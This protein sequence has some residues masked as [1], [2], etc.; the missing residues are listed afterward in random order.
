MPHSL[1]DTISQTCS[2][3]LTRK[4]HL[5]PTNNDTPSTGGSGA[6]VFIA[7]DE[8]SAHYYFIKH[9]SEP[10]NSPSPSISML[11]AEFVGVTELCNTQTMKVPRPIVCGTH[12]QSDSRTSFLV[13]EYVEL[14]PFPEGTTD[15]HREFGRQLA[16]LHRNESSNGKYGFM[17]DN[18]IGA[19]PQTNG[20]MDQWED[21]WQVHRLTPMIHLTSQETWNDSDVSLLTQTVRRLL[22]HRPKPSLVHGDLW[23]G[24]AGYVHVGNDKE[25]KMVPV[26]YDPAPYYGDREVDVAMTELFGG[27]GQEFRE[28]YDSVWALPEGWEQRRTVYNLYHMMNHEV[29]FGGTYR[30][31][32]RDMVVEILNY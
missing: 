10:K 1:L 30:G 27:M 9:M 29:L 3:T 32:V 15:H 6:S 14:L 17:I 31:Q 18:T 26:M 16:R 24:N 25:K 11:Q 21:F 20:W 5:V 4:V 13:L 19:T 2:N 23:V 28:G 22:S 8:Y 12:E 7:R